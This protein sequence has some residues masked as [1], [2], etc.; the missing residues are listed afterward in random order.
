MTGACEQE[1]GASEKGGVLLLFPAA[2]LIVVAL[3]AVAVDSSIAFLAER[4]LAN[5]TAA[6]ANDAAA[7]AVSDRAF[8]EG[9]RIE[10]DPAAVEQVAVNR[11]RAALDSGR[12]HDLGVVARAV[13]P[14]VTGCGWTVH[15]SA[16]ARVSYIFSG[17]VPGGPDSVALD[18]TSVAGPR[19]EASETC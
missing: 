17:A 10:L 6:A 15:V 9:G 12:H 11:V 16:R 19:Q 13:P 8:Y 14:S 3:A 1:Y 7:Q 5:A 2:V 4:E 18:A